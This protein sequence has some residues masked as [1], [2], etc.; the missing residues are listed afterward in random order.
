MQIILKNKLRL[1][2]DFVI[3]ENNYDESHVNHDESYVNLLCLF[4]SVSVFSHHFKHLNTEYES[5][6]KI[7]GCYGAFSLFKFM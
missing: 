2:S 7:V 1:F 4:R 5:D 6:S 3:S